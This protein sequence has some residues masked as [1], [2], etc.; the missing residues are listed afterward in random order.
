MT[1]N[2]NVR[3]HLNILSTEQIEYIHDRS[4]QILSRVGVRV[5][6]SRAMRVFTHS[7]GVKRQAEDRI[8]IEPG[9]VEWAIDAAPSFIDIFNRHGEFAFRLGHKDPDLKPAINHRRPALLDPETND[10][11]HL[12][13]TQNLKSKIENLKSQTRFGV[14]VTNL[15]YQEP[16]TEE[17]APFSRKHMETSVRLGDRL[18][19]Y[20]LISTIGI[21]QD[22]PPEVADLYAVLE[23]VANTTKPLVMLVSDEKLFLPALDL[24]DHLQ[25][26]NGRAQKLASQSSNI[27]TQN[28]VQTHN[29]ASLP[30]NHL[31][32]ISNLKSFVIPYFNPVTP[33]IINRGTADKMLD[34]IQRGLPLIYSNLSMAGMSTP[35][36]SAG[37][38]ALLNAELLAGLVLS[39][40]AREGAP[41][42]LGSLP[43]F[44]DLKTMQDFY[45]PHTILMNL[46]CAEMMAHYR[47]PHAGTSGSGV[48]WGADL[49]GGGLLWMNHLATCMG[50]VGLAPFVGGS[51]ASKVF[52]PALAVYS[53]E[54]IAQARRFAQ[55]FPLDDEWLSLDE[56]ERKGPG[57][58][59][60]DAPLTRKHFRQAYFESA[61]FPRLSLEKWE[62][63]SHPQAEQLL[64]EHT[65]QL[66]E[67]CRPPDDHDELIARGEAFI[68]QFYPRGG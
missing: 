61:I 58:S 34:A 42:I 33:L 68:N 55:G 17:V 35:I 67:D 18:P 24:L 6:S 27:Q 49:L 3:P 5:D 13:E 56:I 50:K 52:S 14:G 16:L 53:D 7:G 11:V 66:L 60:L 29:F 22:Y 4:L 48:G 62:A 32:S 51:F 65:Q 26:Q 59:F 37:T 31:S 43:A 36:T 8:L 19:N 28:H 63:R 20:D 9:L 2:Q 25:S 10:S 23:M 39:Q 40:L 54:V 45:D 30:P 64:R 57:G 12:S 44:F 1:P 46:A 41:V 21:I 47:I 15:Y 38:L